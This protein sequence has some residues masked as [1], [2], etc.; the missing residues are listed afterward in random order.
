MQA[1]VSAQDGHG[2]QISL[3]PTSTHVYES[4]FQADYTEGQLPLQIEVSYQMDGVHPSKEG[5]EV[6]AKCMHPTIDQLMRNREHEHHHLY[7][8]ADASLGTTDSSTGYD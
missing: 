6:L 2:L 7:A 3:V 4:S 8:H 1:L 5:L